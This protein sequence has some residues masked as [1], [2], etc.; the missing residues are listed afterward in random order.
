MVLQTT[1]SQLL[2]FVPFMFES[3]LCIVAKPLR[4][5]DSEC[6]CLA[7]GQARPPIAA[8]WIILRKMGL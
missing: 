4:P 5:R 8:R 2:L 6:G 7:F 3:L 1:F